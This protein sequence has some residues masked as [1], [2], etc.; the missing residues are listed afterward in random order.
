LGH[1]SSAR[2]NFISLEKSLSDDKQYTG[3]GLNQ[4]WKSYTAI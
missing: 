2:C 3:G 4:T 1:L